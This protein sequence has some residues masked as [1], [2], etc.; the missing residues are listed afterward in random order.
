MPANI[1][2]STMHMPLS[3]MDQNS[4][5]TLIAEG[6]GK[7]DPTI[8]IVIGATITVFFLSLLVII[9]LLLLKILKKAPRRQ[10]GT[11]RV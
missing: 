4:V 8:K 11:M 5:V 7:N 2:V 6:K 3:F 10:E 9:V 1:T